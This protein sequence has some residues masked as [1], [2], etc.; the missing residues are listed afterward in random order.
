MLR[1]ACDIGCDSAEPLDDLGHMGRKLALVGTACC[2]KTATFEAVRAGSCD[3]G[4]V[5]VPEAARAI[6]A[7][8]PS[9]FSDH[10]RL[11]DRECEIAERQSEEEQEAASQPGCAVVVL[12]RCLLDTYLYC[13]VMLGD[14]PDR[15]GQ[16]FAF[17]MPTYAKVC[18]FDPEGVE[19]VNDAVRAAS[20]DAALRNRWH[21]VFCE[22]LKAHDDKVVLVTGPLASRVAAV[23]EVI[24]D[25]LGNRS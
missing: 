17:A 15:V 7:E 9:L 6:A 2:W 18:L 1:N 13:K 25:I 8:S 4:V 20:M 24:A 23:E 16:L 21:E 3:P 19:F 11:E 12:D 10:R 5:F 22:E 14:V